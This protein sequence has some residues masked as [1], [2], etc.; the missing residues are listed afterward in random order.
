VRQLDRV[1]PVGFNRPVR[2][3][4]LIEEKGKAEPS[5]EKGVGL[6]H[7]AL[8]V[9][10]AKKWLEAEKAFTRVLEVLPEDGPAKTYIKRCQEFA[11]KPPVESWDGVFNLTAK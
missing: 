4:E 11:A 9:F 8:A 10:E 2:L 6:F 3:F 7:E 1:R 5:V